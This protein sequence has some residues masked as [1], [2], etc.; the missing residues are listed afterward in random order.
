MQQVKRRTTSSTYN[1]VKKFYYI[2]INLYLK[3]HLIGNMA[4]HVVDV[5]ALKS[6]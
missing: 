2:L 1:I 4:G 6:K 5:I 3:I